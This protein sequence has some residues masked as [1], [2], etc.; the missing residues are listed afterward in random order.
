MMREESRCP[1]FTFLVVKLR[2]P[3]ITW[4]SSSFLAAHKIGKLVTD[5]IERFRNC[6][7]FRT[8][9]SCSG[10]YLSHRGPQVAAAKTSRIVVYPQVVS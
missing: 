4:P 9:Q 3:R 6:N 2:G 10:T 7:C 5:W 1:F 8:Y